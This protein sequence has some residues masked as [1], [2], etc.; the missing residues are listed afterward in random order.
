[1]A[2][3]SFDLGHFSLLRSVDS[4]ITT[5]HLAISALIAQCINHAQWERLNGDHK[6][7]SI[8]QVPLRNSFFFLSKTNSRRT[9]SQQF[10][11]YHELKHASF[12]FNGRK[13][14][15]HRYLLKSNLF[16]AAE[17]SR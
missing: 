14:I 13:K 2:E 9:S 12:S 16:P 7:V 15:L 11:H 3:R 6:L 1:M 17:R 4:V 10:S 8:L 5:S